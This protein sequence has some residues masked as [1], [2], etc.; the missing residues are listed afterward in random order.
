MDETTLQGCFAKLDRADEAIEAAERELDVWLA[1]KPYPTRVDVDREKG[2]HR[3]FFDFSVPLPPR[4]PVLLGEITHD[5]RSTLDHVVWREAVEH[6]GPRQAERKHNSIT[7]P[8]CRSRVEFKQ[9]KVKPFVGPDA[10]TIIER[11]QPY[12]RGKPARSKALEL[13]H[14]VNRIDKHRLL[15]GSNVFVGFFDPLKLIE[16]NRN[17]HL[18]AAPLRTLPNV[19]KREVEV[20]C[21]QFDPAGP[22]PNVRVKAPPPL[23]VSYGD[24]P[25]R[26]QSVGISKAAAKV[27]KIVG[28]FSDLIP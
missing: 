22:E 11:H 25:R 20:A 17:A 23:S 2:E 18:I 5:L 28:E 16:W 24:F 7:F 19:L 6:V 15:H 14:W 4:F 1:S 10:W 12:D 8:I 3:V 13:L 9:S 21:Y 26:V 27:R